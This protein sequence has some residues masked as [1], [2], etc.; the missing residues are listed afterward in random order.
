MS[1][2]H[3]FHNLIILQPDNVPAVDLF[4]S[5]KR[6]FWSQGNGYDLPASRNQ[7]EEVWRI[8]TPVLI[9]HPSLPADRLVLTR[10][11]FIQVIMTVEG[12]GCPEI[13]RLILPKS[14]ML[15]YEGEFHSKET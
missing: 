3:N 14:L 8:S 6:S 2:K 11:S 1:I 9:R 10:A 13:C 12:C 4:S 5:H 15:N 7:L